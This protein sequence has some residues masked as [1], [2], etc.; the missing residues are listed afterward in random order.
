MIY[1]ICFLYNRGADWETLRCISSID[2]EEYSNKYF[3]D[4]TLNSIEIF[5]DGGNLVHKQD[6]PDITANIKRAS[7]IIKNMSM[8]IRQAEK[9]LGQAATILSKAINGQ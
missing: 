2:Y 5:D 4:I 7:E 1:H 6:R 8:S 9:D 3:T